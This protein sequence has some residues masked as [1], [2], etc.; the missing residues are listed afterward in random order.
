MHIGMF[1]YNIHVHPNKS[2]Q[3]YSLIRGVIL[4]HPI[5]PLNSYSKIPSSCQ[6]CEHFFFHRVQSRKERESIGKNQNNY[7]IGDTLRHI[8]LSISNFLQEKQHKQELNRPE[9][10]ISFTNCHTVPHT[11]AIIAR[12]FK[13]CLIAMIFI[14][15]NVLSMC[16]DNFSVSLLF[17]AYF[18]S[19]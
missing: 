7:F 15:V 12:M 16:P 6:F 19:L 3:V 11:S 1:M 8:F 4:R 18:T 17:I 13:F 5:K 14:G 10:S 2:V 9:E